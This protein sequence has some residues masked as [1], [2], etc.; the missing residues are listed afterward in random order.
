MD[1]RQISQ[2]EHCFRHGRAFYFPPFSRVT[3]FQ[4]ST[5]NVTVGGR[6]SQASPPSH[7]QTFPSLPGVGLTP[8]F[9]QVPAY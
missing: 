3:I 2:G 6:L 8:T 1:K 5:E 7:R 4:V 9:P